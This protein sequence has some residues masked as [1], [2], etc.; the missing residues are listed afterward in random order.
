MVFVEKGQTSASRLLL[1]WK[2]DLRVVVK[3]GLDGS[4]VHGAGSALGHLG[5]RYERHP[6]TTAAHVFKGFQ[7]AKD[8]R[9]IEAGTPPAAFMALPALW[10]TRFSNFL[11]CTSHY[12][13]S[14][15]KD[16]DIGYASGKMHE[17]VLIEC[18]NR[19]L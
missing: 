18:E 9:R 6:A 14:Q 10:Y 2:A 7:V 3:H 13:Q 12:K 11:G 5:I 1:G 8:A 15:E 17:D 4:A 19:I 16:K